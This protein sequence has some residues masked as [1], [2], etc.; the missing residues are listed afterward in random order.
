MYIP[1]RKKSVILRNEPRCAENQGAI[2]VLAAR[3]SYL[4][5]MSVV[6]ARSTMSVWRLCD[7][8][9]VGK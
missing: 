7:L 4:E 8:S 2:G 5:V 1:Q 3:S 6:E 9:S